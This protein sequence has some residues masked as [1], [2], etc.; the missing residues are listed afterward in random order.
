MHSLES[1]L[2]GEKAK[3]HIHGKKFGEILLHDSVFIYV[4]IC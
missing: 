4:V 1:V 3:Y 2:D